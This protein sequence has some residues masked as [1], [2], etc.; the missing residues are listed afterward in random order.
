MT[1]Y[2]YHMVMKRIR[3]AE[4]KARLSEHLRYVREGHEVTVM[5]RDSP[6]ARIVPF[7]APGILPSRPPAVDAE[8]PGQLSFPAP[9]LPQVDPVE[10]LLEERQSNR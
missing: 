4:L 3:I 6:V 1:T 7:N 10:H 2:D 8:P 5:D 9:L